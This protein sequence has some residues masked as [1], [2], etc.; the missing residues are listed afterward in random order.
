MDRPVYAGEMGGYT[1]PQTLDAF[2]K[3]AVEFPRLRPKETPF[4]FETGHLD[5]IYGVGAGAWVQHMDESTSRFPAA[6]MKQTGVWYC[7][8]TC[9]SRLWIMWAIGGPKSKNTGRI[10]GFWPQVVD[11]SV[12]NVDE[13]V[14]GG[15]PARAGGRGR[16]KYSLASAW[17][18][19]IMYAVEVCGKEGPA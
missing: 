13:M 8:P 1:Y 9:G 14:R 7:A 12:D 6:P 11:K 19:A 18:S 2:W 15:F 16:G 3:N 17:K 4:C 5:T 10:G